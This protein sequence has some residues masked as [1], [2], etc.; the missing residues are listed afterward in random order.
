MKSKVVSQENAE[1][2]VKDGERSSSD[3]PEESNGSKSGRRQGFIRARTDAAQKKCQ[4][5]R[6][7]ICVPGPIVLAYLV[8]FTD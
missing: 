7:R 5:P 2:I 6:R 1:K 3:S 4:E 8:L